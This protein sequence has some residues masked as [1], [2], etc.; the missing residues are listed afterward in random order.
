MSISSAECFCKG[1]NSFESISFKSSLGSTVNLAVEI[2]SVV[3]EGSA[4][5]VV[6]LVFKSVEAVEVVTVTVMVVDV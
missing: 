3:V 5:A 4:V 1:L 6:V 2:D